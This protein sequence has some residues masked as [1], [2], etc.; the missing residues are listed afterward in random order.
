VLNLPCRQQHPW[1]HLA[2]E[3][4]PAA[5]AY[6]FEFLKL[7]LAEYSALQV[8]EA[9][10]AKAEAFLEAIEDVFS[11]AYEVAW[12]DLNSFDMICKPLMRSLIAPF[13]KYLMAC[14]PSPNREADFKDQFLRAKRLK[15]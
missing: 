2:P 14:I 4:K 7:K 5:F 8:P 9:L 1:I 10:R 3:F 12:A 11:L 15:K 6:D 13:R